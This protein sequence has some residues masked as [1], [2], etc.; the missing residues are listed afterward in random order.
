MAEWEETVQLVLLFFVMLG[1]GTT[2]DASKLKST[3]GRPVGLAIALLL[4]FVM[5]P[6]LSYGL[7]RAFDLPS[8]YAVGLVCICC[9]PG[10]AVSNILCF[11]FQADVTLSVAM[12]TASSILACGLMP[13]NL[14]LYLQQSGLAKDVDLEPLGIVISAVIVVA[15]T[16][17]GLVS[18][19]RVSK[20]VLRVVE[21]LGSIAG[22][23]SILL[24]FIANSLSD[25]PTW[26]TPVR[27]IVAL[28]IPILVGA[29]VGIGLAK[30][31]NLEWPSAIAIGIEVSCQNKLVAVAVVSA[32]LR[33]DPGQRDLA[34]AI[35]LLYAF[36]STVL[37][38]TWCLVAWRLGFTYLDHSAGCNRAELWAAFTKAQHAQGLGAELSQS[39]AIAPLRISGTHESDEACRQV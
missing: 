19:P 17:L 39:D 37:N 23:G 31:S 11:I 6:A 29:I 35:P 36:F 16:I 34:Y 8:A 27:D 5:M 25:T 18:G 33:S 32:T 13:F 21:I 12:T 14:W 1:L 20:R 2:I 26:G 4:Q 7:S 9:A 3:F 10:G 24:A 38:A 30:M 22:V 15:G 28:N